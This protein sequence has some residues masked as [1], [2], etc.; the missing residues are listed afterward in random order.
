MDNVSGILVKP[1][2]E[3]ELANA[4]CFLLKNERM[5]KR[6]GKIGA[7]LMKKFSWKKTIDELERLYNSIAFSLKHKQGIEEN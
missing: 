3:E 7:K 1:K 2:S 4:I 5:R 6:M